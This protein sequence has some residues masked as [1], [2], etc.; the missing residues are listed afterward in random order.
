[1]LKTGLKTFLGFLFKTKFHINLEFILI[2][3]KYSYI[4]SQFSQDKIPVSLKLSIGR[5]FALKLKLKLDQSVVLQVK[6]SL[7]FELKIKII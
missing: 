4:F 3:P 6:G 7:N 1:M 2:D 5:V